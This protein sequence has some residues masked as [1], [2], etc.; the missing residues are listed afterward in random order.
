M[1]LGYFTDGVARERND[2][3]YVFWKWMCMYE[4]G[5]LLGVQY[6][7]LNTFSLLLR[8]KIK[9]LTIFTQ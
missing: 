3:E 4:C 6:D 1:D 7:T 8:I 9:L 5:T 2:G